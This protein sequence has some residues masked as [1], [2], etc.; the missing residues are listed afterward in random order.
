LFR[1]QV[2]LRWYAAILVGVPA[3]VLL[4]NPDLPNITHR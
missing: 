2:G 1:Q 4:A 3:T